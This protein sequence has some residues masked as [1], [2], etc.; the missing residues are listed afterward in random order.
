[1]K[2]LISGGGT[3][4]HIFPAISIA[5]EIK[6]HF[7]ESEILFVGANG[8]MEMERVP[9][10]GYEI[11]GLDTRGLDR[12]KLWKN[13]NIVVDFV[14]SYFKAKKIVK[15]FSPVV[16]IGV[17]G[18][19]SGAAMWAAASLGVPVV[20]QEQN[21]FAGLTNRFLS[22]KA[23]AICVAYEN[24]ERFFP[25]DK[26]ILTGNPI[27]QNLLQPSV[28]RQIAYQYF[29]FD[30]NKKTL[31]VVGGSLGAGTIN[32]SLLS[33]LQRLQSSNFQVIWQT[34]KNYLA[35]IRQSLIEQ[36]FIDKQSNENPIRSNNFFIS[37]FISNMN[38]AYCIADLVVSRAG[39]SSISELSILGKPSLLVPS[40]NVS[41]N[42]QYHNAMAL[43]NK[44]A[45]ILVEDKDAIQNLVPAAIKV[46]ENDQTLN[47]LSQNIKKL[48]LE[49]S[50]TKIVEV[51]KDV[52]TANATK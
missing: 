12:K 11:V 26:I 28:E 32:I 14:K 23:T 15:E 22:K 18:Y 46:I 39:A 6:K 49:N 8:R 7:P 52:I 16:A 19:V 45:A 38:Y 51:I 30:P 25:K 37:E 29:G 27:R 5:N 41:E 10:A 48:A 13:F 40:P 24:M 42:H 35:G 2:F 36:K 43:V 20:L 21:S 47:M 31:L 44:D 3:G 9:E 1:M 50:A 17:G 4:G 33:Q 34:G